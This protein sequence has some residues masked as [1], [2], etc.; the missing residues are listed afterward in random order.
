MLAV[1]SPQTTGLTATS[2][3]VEAEEDDEPALPGGPSSWLGFMQ[4][5]LD[6]DVAEL[7]GILRL[8]NEMLSLIS[9][10]SCMLSIARKIFLSGK[11]AFG[12]L[13]FV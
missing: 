12:L 11:F 10:G 6:V 2:I 9:T 5:F 7:A 1:P 8:I 13:F 4:C 3:E